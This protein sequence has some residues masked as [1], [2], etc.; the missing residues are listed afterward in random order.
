M[1]E[2][3]A[4]PWTVGLITAGAFVLGLLFWA[5][6]SFVQAQNPKAEWAPVSPVGVPVGGQHTAIQI[7]EAL[8]NL[9]R[10]EATRMAQQ[11]R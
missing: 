4:T 7:D 10:Q 1:Q 11:A 6:T 8:K 2:Y 9:Q 3:D 5:A